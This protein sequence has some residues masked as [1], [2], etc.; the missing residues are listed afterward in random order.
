MKHTFFF[1]ALILLTLSTSCKKGACIQGVVL[2][3]KTNQPVSS[4][5]VDLKYEYSESGSLKS[6]TTTVYSDQ[7]G[8][9]SFSND[10]KYSNPIFVLDV[11]HA[12]YGNHFDVERFEGDCAD[13]QVKLNPLDGLLKL[14]ITNES[15][16]SDTVFAGVF[17]KCD[18]RSLY[19]TGV[20]LT[21]P[22]AVVLQ[23][24][25][26]FTQTF[27][28]C[29]GDSSAVVWRFSKYGPWTGVDSLWVD[30]EDEMLREIKY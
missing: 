24:G 15:G 29:V 5:R 3:S 12:A 21:N 28:T 25:G 30:S 8:E 22:A 7:S 16:S 11:Q 2:D 20:S 17:N 26:Q 18:Y 27:K 14:T 10:E 19:Y 23:Q 1:F 9:F 4:A 13:V 6:T